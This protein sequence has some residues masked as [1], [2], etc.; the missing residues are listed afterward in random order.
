VEARGLLKQALIM[1]EA[2]VLLRGLRDEIVALFERLL[3]GS[4]VRT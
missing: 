4:G 2:D 3:A 1:A